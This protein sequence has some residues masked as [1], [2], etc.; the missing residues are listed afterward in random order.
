MTNKQRSILKGHHMTAYYRRDYLCQVSASYTGNKNSLPR[1]GYLVLTTDSPHSRRIILAPALIPNKPKR[2]KGTVSDI[3]QGP[4]CRP[5]MNDDF[6]DLCAKLHCTKILLC[7]A[8]YISFH[9]K[10]HNERCT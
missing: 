1:A 2:E 9:L 10:R 4:G 5:P 6:I 8:M 7:Q 3:E